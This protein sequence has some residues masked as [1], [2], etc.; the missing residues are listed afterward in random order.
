MIQ[1]PEQPNSSTAES[2]NYSAI[3]GFFDEM[4]ETPSIPRRHWRLFMESMQRL[5]R[6]ELISRWHDG[7]RLIRE[8]GVT[9]NVY[10]DPRGMDRPWGLDLVPL[11]LTGEVWARLEAGLIQR[12]HLLN[13]V[14]AD[15][16]GGAQRLIR[17]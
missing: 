6:E 16:Y 1:E 17:D 2:F 15:I 3:P 9:Y 8:H 11:L 10:G 7:R 12:S 14:L 4:E 5:G 13:L